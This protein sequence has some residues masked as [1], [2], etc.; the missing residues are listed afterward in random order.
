MYRCL[1]IFIAIIFT[2]PIWAQETAS[3]QPEQKHDFKLVQ[4]DWNGIIVAQ[5]YT[6]TLEEAIEAAATMPEVTSFI[7]F[8][9]IV[10]GSDF[11][12]MRQ[13]MTIFFRKDPSWPKPQV[14]QKTQPQE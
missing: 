4:G 12:D 7:Y 10:D 2:L 13:S 1:F 8:D 14:Y 11:G 9:Q 5:A 6:L 3:Q